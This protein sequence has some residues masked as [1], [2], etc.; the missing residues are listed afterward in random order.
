MERSYNPNTRGLSQNEHFKY[1]KVDKQF[2]ITQAINDKIVTGRHKVHFTTLALRTDSATTNLKSI[3]DM[4][5]VCEPT[6]NGNDR[7]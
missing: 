6:P 1:R 5:R 7:I 2:Q 4:A 3:L